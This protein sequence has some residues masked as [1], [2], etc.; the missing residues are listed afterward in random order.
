MDNDKPIIPPRPKTGAPR[1]SL[2]LQ[3]PLEDNDAFGE[4]SSVSKSVE[5]KDLTEQKSDIENQKETNVEA[6]IP[7]AANVLTNESEPQE[8][9]TSTDP[10]I[11]KRP[12]RKK[13]SDSKVSNIKDENLESSKTIIQVTGGSSSPGLETSTPAIDD[14][15]LQKSTNDKHD[16]PMIPQRPSKTTS[17]SKPDMT[18][19]PSCEDNNV[20]SECS[21]TTLSSNANGTEIN[22]I[23]EDKNIELSS[24]KV[25]P[26]EVTE[27]N[28]IE[29]DAGST[30]KEVEGLDHEMSN[31]P[32]DILPDDREIP[33]D[34]EAARVN[35]EEVTHKKD[36]E[37]E[38]VEKENHDEKGKP[39]EVSDTSK[40]HE[41]AMLNDEEVT[42]KAN[43][44]NENDDEKDKPDEASDT[45]KQPDA[46]EISRN[47]ST[48]STSNAPSIPQRP[49]LKT[50]KSSKELSD[51]EKPQPTNKPKAP[52]KPKNLSS[53]IAAFQEMLNQGTSIAPGSNKSV[54]VPKKDNAAA[55]EDSSGP[56]RLSS[57]RM[58]FAQSLQGLVGK[59]IPP[60]PIGSSPTANRV[61]S[62]EGAETKSEKVTHISKSRG[63]K[64]K[65]L[66]GSL[67]N[68]A[69]LEAK[70]R[71][72]ITTS[73][74][75]VIDYKLHI[76]AEVNLPTDIEKERGEGGEE[77]KE[78]TGEDA[79][80][81]EVHLLVHATGGCDSDEQVC[82]DLVY[83]DDTK[84]LLHPENKPR[85]S[86]G[87][88]D[89]KAPIN[90]RDIP[91]PRA[92]SSLSGE[93]ID[94]GSGKDIFPAN[95]VCDFEHTSSSGA[96]SDDP[97]NHTTVS[98][99]TLHK[100]D[101][102]LSLIDNYLDSQ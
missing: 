101:S 57:D 69:V 50:V 78:V 11:P 29:E 33:S 21:A 3:L 68:P 82:G 66:P 35:D 26:Q 59:G 54:A 2:R 102:E 67:K 60:E 74:L 75:W 37:K 28:K 61:T 92:D 58:K 83:S 95:T 79:R 30:D 96:K 99:N 84:E 23:K 24:P 6:E 22:D 90:V 10:V 9:A 15:D 81:E 86:S 42:D 34:S 53:K 88:Y 31:T 20:K 44:K 71:F 52:P 55:Q 98:S 39:D 38:N 73:Q 64:K 16:L 27:G 65:R 17:K 89:V 49:R 1:V 85:S 25:K 97:E 47:A 91:D 77:A 48:T 93:A 56:S 5:S 19:R 32:K 45:S 51:S 46:G 70:T 7:I 40:Q 14:K 80:E 100:N 63:P 41:V 8:G 4:I 87:E 13:N 12:E 43:F 36:A 72:N 94:T 76:D 62:D 18:G